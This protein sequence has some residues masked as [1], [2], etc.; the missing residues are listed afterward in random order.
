MGSPK[1]RLM[2]MEEIYTIIHKCGSNGADK[3]ML[4]AS[5]CVKTG[6]GERRIKEYLRLMI[7]AGKVKEIDKKLFISS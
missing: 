3:K 1:E 2:R 4:I 5:Y 6:V 7:D